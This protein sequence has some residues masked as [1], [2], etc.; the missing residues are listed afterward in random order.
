MPIM[1][2]AEARLQIRNRGTSI[3]PRLSDDTNS[4]VPLPS[5]AS[6]NTIHT[7]HRKLHQPIRS[8]HGMNGPD[9]TN[10]NT[11]RS[12]ERFIVSG[13]CGESMKETAGGTLVE[14]LFEIDLK[15]NR[16]LLKKCS[17]F[18]HICRTGTA[19]LGKI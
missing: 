11:L 12:R 18:I 15:E 8:S 3:L 1:K 7:P 6:R 5:N 4:T 10:T 2:S 9:Q 17:H 14:K 19:T 13:T 16:N